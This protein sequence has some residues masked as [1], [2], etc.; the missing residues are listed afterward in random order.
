MMEILSLQ[1]AEKDYVKD[2]ASKRSLQE[3]QQEQEFQQWWDQESKRVMLEEEQMKRTE[4]RAVKASQGRVRG[5]G[6]KSKGKGKEK[7]DGDEAET[8]KGSKDAS[9][10]AETQE[11]A[12]PKSTP[13]HDSSDKGR[14]RGGYRG[15]RGGGGRGGRGP[16]PT[17]DGSATP[18]SAPKEQNGSA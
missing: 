17:K 13:K 6:G 4:E 16:R 9:V 8:S 2:A 1:Q 11:V 18:M 5:R 14:G 12:I 15:G 10:P 3:I 7:K